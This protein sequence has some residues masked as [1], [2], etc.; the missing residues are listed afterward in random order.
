MTVA[1]AARPRCT[2]WS[3]RPASKVARQASNRSSTSSTGRHSPLPRPVELVD[4]TSVDDARA[5]KS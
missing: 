1:F 4:A 2:D 5:A 3:E